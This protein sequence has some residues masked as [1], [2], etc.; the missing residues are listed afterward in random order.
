M[1]KTQT[2]ILLLLASLSVQIAYCQGATSK[3]DT[4]QSGELMLTQEITL[5]APVEK[6]WKAFTKASEWKKWVTPVAEIDWKINGTIK[7]HYDSTAKIGDPGT[8]VNHILTYIPYKQI[9]MQG[10]IADNFP[11]FMKGEEKNMYAIFDFQQLNQNTTKV[12]IYGVG[13]RNEKRW[14]DLLKFFIQGNEMTLNNL[15]KY[16]EHL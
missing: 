14:Q 9:T 1:M 16:V 2:L 11:E 10:E 4:L 12:T 3:V 7:S 5:A 6:I 15:K 13:Y 8:I